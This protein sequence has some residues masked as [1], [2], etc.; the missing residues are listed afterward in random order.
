MVTDAT[1]VTVKINGEVVLVDGNSFSKSVDLAVGMNTFTITAV[2]AAG[3]TTVKILSVTRSGAG[4]EVPPTTTPA[5]SQRLPV[6]IGALGAMII[7]LMVLMKMAFEKYQR[8]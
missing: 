8:H 7:V 6:F 1:G 3:N 5:P 2:D 4:V